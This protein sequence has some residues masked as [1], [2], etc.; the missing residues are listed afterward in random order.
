VVIEAR[1]LISFQSPGAFEGD[2]A[3]L[4]A[5]GGGVQQVGDGLPQL[6]E[7]KSRRGFFFPTAVRS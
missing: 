2:A 7:G 1:D 6:W 4:V 5:A 3:W